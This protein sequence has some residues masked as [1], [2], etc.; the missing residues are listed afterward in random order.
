MRF[1]ERALLLHPLGN[2]HI[3]V[4]WERQYRWWDIAPAPKVGDP[5]RQLVERT[6]HHASKLR[7]EMSTARA[8]VTVYTS[9]E[10]GGAATRLIL[11]ATAMV[12]TQLE[13]QISV[14]QYSVVDVPALL[15]AHRTAS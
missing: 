8:T 12:S 4:D 7:G 2:G 1:P 5:C 15:Q 3:M 13:V 9:Q 14:G 10:Y 11:L 6:L